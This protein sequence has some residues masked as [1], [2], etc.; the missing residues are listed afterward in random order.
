MIDPREPFFPTVMASHVIHGAG[1]GYANDIL[2]G[3]SVREG[4]ALQCLQ[5]LLAN[6]ALTESRVN[7]DTYVTLAMGAADRF[8]AHINSELPPERPPAPV[9]PIK[10]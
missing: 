4:V 7:A 9:T 2:G 3:L 8:L 1:G 10:P 5:G 6:P